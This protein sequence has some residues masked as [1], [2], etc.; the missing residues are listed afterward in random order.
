LDIA[1]QGDP[2]FV[3]ASVSHHKLRFVFAVAVHTQ[4]RRKL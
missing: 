4:A 1:R 3:A 2:Q